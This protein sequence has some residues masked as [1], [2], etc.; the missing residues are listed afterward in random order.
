M[1]QHECLRLLQLDALPEDEAVI[2]RAFRKESLKHHPDKNKNPGN[3]DMFIKLDRAR[4][5]LIETLR[6][7]GSHS[8]F[9]TSFDTS[10]WAF[11]LHNFILQHQGAKL[12]IDITVKCTLRQ[13]YD[14]ETLHI[15]VPVNRVSIN[16]A[17][18]N[19]QNQMVQVSKSVMIKLLPE[20]ADQRLSKT[21]VFK[22]EG[23]DH[24]MG[25]LFPNFSMR[26]DIVVHFEFEER[27]MIDGRYCFID[28][29]I[30]PRDLCVEVP[31]TLYEYYMGGPK[32]FSFMSYRGVIDVQR[33]KK[34]QVVKIGG[35]GLPYKAPGEEEVRRGDLYV[36]TEVALPEI[37]EAELASDATIVDAIKCLTRVRNVG[38]GS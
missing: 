8:A 32:P 18:V 26:G 28:T 1:D 31:I 3:S 15:S 30:N 24:P 7:G 4:Q 6:G 22:C 25:L 21:V 11:N 34:K 38:P 20:G 36:I 5:Q 19:P 14:A 16:R 2:E 17:S 23:N 10:M 33:F 9:D 13:L 29:V 35:H 12:G 37:S 27:A